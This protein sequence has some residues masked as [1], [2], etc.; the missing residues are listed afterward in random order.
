M[1]PE[2]VARIGRLMDTYGPLLTDR[3]RHAMDLY[4]HE[5][6]SLG[7]VAAELG[8][9]RQGVHDLLRRTEAVLESYERSLGLA[10]R[11][12]RQRDGLE[13]LRAVLE[14]LPAAGAGAAGVREALSIVDA[15]LS[16]QGGD[17]DAG[18]AVGTAATGIRPAPE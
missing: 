7:E 2:R 3:Q 17:V 9:S 15:L 13:R 12:E 16:E 18:R 11:L 10:G 5:D 8:I 4:F 14:R 6:L 1:L